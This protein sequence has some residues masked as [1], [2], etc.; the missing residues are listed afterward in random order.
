M[1]WTT[2]LRY[3][4]IAT[5]SWIISYYLAAFASSNPWIKINKI[6]PMGLARVNLQN[7]KSLT[8]N[9][10]NP[11][12]IQNEEEL[13]LLKSKIKS[14]IG[15]DP[16]GNAYQVFG[17]IPNP[18]DQTKTLFPY[19]SYGIDG[20]SH[21]CGNDPDDINLW[22]D[23]HQAHY[24]LQSKLKQSRQILISALVLA[25]W[26]FVFLVFTQRWHAKRQVKTG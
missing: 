20:K 11:D 18:S 5:L 10:I 22:D 24:E 6:T 17:R 4:F 23:H 16:W 9:Q 2:Y 1:Q 13:Q 3:T 15:M 14:E 26:V 8:I 21:T 7:I 19:Y 12:G 25:P